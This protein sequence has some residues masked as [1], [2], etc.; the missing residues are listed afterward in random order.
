MERPS[1]PL[2]ESRIAPGLQGRTRGRGIPFKAGY[3]Q[4]RFH[5]SGELFG[6]HCKRR[7]VVALPHP[8]DEAIFEGGGRAGE[9]CA[10]LQRPQPGGWVQISELKYFNF[11]FNLEEGRNI[12]I[13]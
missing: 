7:Q 2:D 10:P 5:G 6:G 9:D 1:H 11:D 8:R 3:R 4:R 12:K 13:I